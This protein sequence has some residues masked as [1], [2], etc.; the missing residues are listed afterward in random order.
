MNEG[1][2]L[3]SDNPELQRAL[4]LSLQYGQFVSLLKVDAVFTGISTGTDTKKPG[5][6]GH[7]RFLVFIVEIVQMNP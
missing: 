6:Q 5:V 3:C 1:F 4:F 2:H 7:T